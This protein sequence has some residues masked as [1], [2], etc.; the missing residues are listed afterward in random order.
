MKTQQ[1]KAFIKINKKLLILIISLLILILILNFNLI[2][3]SSH[4][5]TTQQTTRSNQQQTTTTSQTD[6]QTNQPWPAFNVCCEKTKTGA[7]CQNTKEDQCDPNFRKTPTSCDATSFCKLGCC[8][9]SEEGLCMENTPQ[10]VCEISKGTWLNDEKCQV[11]Q[12][13]LGCCTIGDQ[14]SF[15]TLTR[16][17]RLSALYGLKTNFRTDINNEAACILTAYSSEKGACVFESEGSKTCTMTSRG[18]CQRKNT[19]NTKSEFFKDYLCS[20]DVLGTN[21]GPTTET[22]CIE[23]RDEVYFKDSCGNPANI[24]DSNRIYSKDPSYW[25]KI[26]PKSESCGAKSKNGNAG[27]ATCGNC[28]YISGSIC[29]KGKAVYGELTC[30][31]LNCYNTENGNNYKNG[32]SWCIYQGDVGKGLDSVGSRHF[33]HIC[34]NGEETIEPCADFRNEVCFQQELETSDGN[35]IEAACRVNRWNDCIDQIDQ[36]SCE[37]TDKR[38]C[39]WL[40]GYYY[41]KS[42]KNDSTKGIAPNDP[43]QEN[44]GILKGTKDNGICLPNYPPGLEFWKEGNAKSICS[45]GNSRQTVKFEEGFF[46]GKKCSENCDVL[47]K[48]WVEEL[49]NVCKSLGDCGNYINFVGRATDDGVI[50]KDNG[51]IRKISQGVAEK[52]RKEEE[53]KGFF[54]DLFG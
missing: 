32:E 44:F 52:A 25:Q 39:Y 26:V 10:K 2:I 33:R 42:S 49:N 29:K 37:N 6:Q 30:K 53:D 18:D 14:A 8:V 48:K 34:I 40:K 51:I 22:T 31:D 54:E 23:T 38:E 12:C 35:F 13:N 24:Y 17:K 11:S 50:V 47:T 19:N 3:A 4:Q 45:L 36:E 20:A 1:N 43:K 5:A 41:D 27:S 28:N 7:W 21:C 9:D 46:G 15:V 16:C